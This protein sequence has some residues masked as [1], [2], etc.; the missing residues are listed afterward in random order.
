MTLSN[1]LLRG[2]TS[3]NR[4]WRVIIVLFVSI[5]L[6]AA[7]LAF[8]FH[9]ALKE[10]FGDSMMPQR[11]LESFD[12]NVF[13]DFMREHPGFLQP[14]GAQVVWL[15]IFWLVLNT[16][17]G[18]GIIA[19]LQRGS[20]ESFAEFF[21]DCGKY[22]GRFFL[23]FL[24]A[25]V[26]FT[27]ISTVWLMMVGIVYASLTMGSTTEVAGV[28]WFFIA[29]G[30]FLLPLFLLMI[31]FDYTRVWIVVED[32][33][34]ILSAFWQSTKFV[35]RHFLTTFGWQLLMILG[36]LILGLLYWLLAD[37]LAMATGLSIFV[38]FLLQQISVGSRIW[39]RLVMIGGQIQVFELH[40]VQEASAASVG[41]VAQAATPLPPVPAVPVKKARSRTGRTVERR[42]GKRSGRRTR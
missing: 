3:T 6:L 1:I 24:F 37:S 10:G 7:A 9:S 27:I 12:S 21:S 42:G 22:L 20:S 36:L 18:G 23:L 33:S 40:D 13:N 38:A 25:A 31:V 29:A 16:L 41:F 39:A 14:F 11:L 8:G 5:L 32:S 34:S 35:F 19:A 15:A 30:V 26:V 2:I 4:S 28:V 17:L